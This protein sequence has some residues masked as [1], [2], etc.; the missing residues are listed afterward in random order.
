MIMAKTCVDG[1]IIQANSEAEEMKLKQIYEQNFLR[2][3]KEFVKT[4]KSFQ[5]KVNKLRED[6]INTYDIKG[7]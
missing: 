4:N 5:N 7:I 2:L 1:F 6:F 3:L